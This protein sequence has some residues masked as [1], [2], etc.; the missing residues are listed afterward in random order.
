MSSSPYP[1]G[2]SALARRLRREIEGEIHFDPL[3]RGI[4]S[5][6]ASIYQIEPIGVV[7]P[8]T[9]EDVVCLLQIA[10]ELEVPVLPRGAGTSQAGQAIGRALVVDTTKYLTRIGEIDADARRVRV[11]PGTVLDDLNRLLRPHGLFFP[12]DVATASRATL[13]GMAG[14][15]SA[16]AR[17]IRYGM[18]VDN[19][20][21]LEVILQDGRSMRLTRG[22]ATSEATEKLARAVGAIREREADE[23]ERRIPSVQRHVAGYNLHR[24]GPSGE[25]LVRLLVGSEGTLAFFTEL[26]LDLEPL[27]LHT[28]LGVCHF[29]DLAGALRTV[30]EIVE[31]EPTAVELVD[32]AL[33]D[34]ARALPAFRDRVSSFVRGDPKAL[35]LV[36]FAGDD[37]GVLLRRMD[38]LENLL[39]D[40]GY[41]GCVLRAPEVELQEEIWSVRRAAMNVVMSK[42]GQGRPVSFIEDCALP[43]EHLAEYTTR[44]GEIFDRYG[45]SGIWYAHASVGCLHIRPVLN[46]ASDRDLVS[47]RKIAEAAHELVREFGGSHS[48]EHGDGIAR[49]EFLKPALGGRLVGAFE[50]VKGLFDPAGL[51]NPGKIVDPPLMDDATLLRRR[52]GGVALPMSPAFDWQEWG[53]ALAAAEMCNSNGACRRVD[54]GVMCPSFRVT[55]D[56]RHSTRGRANALR[57]ALSGQWGEDGLGSPELEEAMDLCIGC[58]ACRRECPAGVDMSRLKIEF[59]YQRRKRVG[60]TVRDKLFAYLPR[61]APLVGGWAPVLNAATRIG[62]AT[63]VARRFLRVEARDLPA[64]RR[65]SFSSSAPSRGGR[66]V[67]LWS[68]TFNRYF[69]PENLEAATR[70][71]SAAGFSVTCADPMGERPLCCGRTFLSAGLVDEAR[72]EL[73]RTVEA[74]RLPLEAGVPIVGLEPSCLLTFKDEL[75]VLLPSESAT[76]LAE[77][78]FLFE[79]FLVSEGLSETLALG[80]TPYSRVHVHAHCHEKAFGLGGA[81]LQVLSWPQGLT[82]SPVAAGCCGMAG[83]FGLESEHSALSR[84][85]AGLGL[86]PALKR[87]S[88]GDAVVAT[89]FSC[90][91][92]IRRIS[93]RKAFHGAQILAGALPETTGVSASEVEKK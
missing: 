20:H 10:R 23:L 7:L 93:G 66:G 62:A 57:L 5:T 40:L 67:I 73:E 15:N 87:V 80:A 75:Q 70:V 26:E 52:S 55:Q 32:G 63:G 36:E 41:P 28:V 91:A 49:S 45:T 86:H 16:G 83:S 50:E 3:T 88:D 14:N 1:I 53:G 37:R 8:R 42:K 34:L 12:V 61:Y 25:D 31:L 54:P 13:G 19:V 69:E 64:W 22:P 81:A 76:L 46:L 30:Q 78:A 84:K 82:A 89:G 39:A 77:R 11:E 58:K 51:M 6:D 27:P 92:Q 33:I 44:L 9:R 85:M 4:Y 2:D 48:G 21:A 38:D 43:L 72:A 90:R 29:P 18:M 79:D 60:L 35:L 74:L 24:V 71:L 56:E 65:R 47:M 17:S 68:D 59:L